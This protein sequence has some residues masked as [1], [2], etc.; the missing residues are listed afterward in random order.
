MKKIFKIVVTVILV[1]LMFGD[2]FIVLREV[3]KSN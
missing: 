2:L 1:L 3:L